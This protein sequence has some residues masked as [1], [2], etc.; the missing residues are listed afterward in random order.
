VNWRGL[1]K[2]MGDLVQSRE[3]TLDKSRREEWRR[4]LDGVVRVRHR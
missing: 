3:E 2:A 1:E 4:Q